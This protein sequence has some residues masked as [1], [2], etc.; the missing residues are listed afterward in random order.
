MVAL[1]TGTAQR[2]PGI[3]LVLSDLSL[4]TVVVVIDV[5]GEFR[6]EGV[7]PKDEYDL[8]VRNDKNFQDWGD[9]LF[10]LSAGEI[11]TEHGRRSIL[12]RTPKWQCNPQPRAIP[13]TLIRRIRPAGFSSNPWRWGKRESRCQA[14]QAFRFFSALP[15]PKSHP[16]PVGSGA[17]TFWEDGGRRRRSDPGSTEP[18]P[19]DDK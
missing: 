14:Y 11:R 4:D 10:D 5:N 12:C 1:L 9:L 8:W 16:G 13:F 6:M 19:R 7:V 18:D 17:S 3:R 15:Y 2:L